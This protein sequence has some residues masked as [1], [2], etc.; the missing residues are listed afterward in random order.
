L[1][2]WT[3]R[4]KGIE[5]W[6]FARRLR[7]ALLGCAL[8]AAGNLAVSRTYAQDQDESW[9]ISHIV[10]GKFD[11]LRSL[12]KLSGQGVPFAL[13]WWGLILERCI[14][15]RCDGDAGR[16]LI[17]RAAL[18]GN[19]RA[20]AELLAGA[21]TREEFDEVIAKI[22]VPSG[23]RERLNYITKSLFLLEAALV[24]GGRRATDDKLRADLL[25]IAKSE[26]H[27]GARIFVAML[28]RQTSSDLD[29]L[30]ATGTDLIS[31]KLM[32]NATVKKIGKQ[33][34]IERARAGE[35][36][37]AAANCDGHVFRATTLDRDELEVC[38]K[39]AGSGFLAA[40]RGLLFFHHQFTGNTRAAQYFADLC[41]TVLGMRCADLLAEYYHDRS[42]ESA[43]LKAKSEFW[44]LAAV[45]AIASRDPGRVSEELLRGKTPRLRRELFQ[46]IVRTALINEACAMQRVDLATGAIEANPQCPWR[47]PIA[48][49]AEFLTTTR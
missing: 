39:A 17:L 18:A 30:A 29:A 8:L 46:L 6:S 28:P 27:I 15:E 31:E 22:G 4:S 11:E 44:E 9:V 35:L 13:Y 21:I 41:E 38:E 12:E 45:N 2:T 10:A 43:E 33:Q 34:I 24:R 40:V 19:S 23:G 32:V 20:K 36:G 47:K 48:I 49:P 3:S 16:E 26:P 1:E 5:G 14:F 42:K 7:R 37:W 25:A